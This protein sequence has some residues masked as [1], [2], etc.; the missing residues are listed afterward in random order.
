[1]QSGA[2]LAAA[3]YA[4][5]L[6]FRL[7]P[8]YL[9]AGFNFSSHMVG[10][11]HLGSCR[12]RY[13]PTRRGF[14]S[15]TGYWTGKGDYYQH[16]NVEGAAGWTGYDFRHNLSVAW[17][18]FGDYATDL[19]T[20]EAEKVIERHAKGPSIKLRTSGNFWGFLTPSP[21]SAFWPDMYAVRI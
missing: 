10:K 13:L 2:L 15:H 21:L 19:F 17:G 11:W 4:L 3:P 12:E 14:E 6:K 1:M 18:D 7:L 9:N 5:P 20:A 16:T 8:E